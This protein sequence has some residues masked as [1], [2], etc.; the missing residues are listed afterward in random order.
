MMGDAIR[1]AV[2]DDE[3]FFQEQ[4]RK[5]LKKAACF[6]QQ[7]FQTEC[8][9]GAASLCRVLDTGQSFDVYFL[10]IDM[11]KMDGIALGKKIR[12]RTADP[13]IIFVSSK[14]GKVF[15]TFS[16]KPFQFIR[17]SSLERDF[18][19]VMEALIREM[20]QEKKSRDIV[21]ES[22]G[23]S[24]RFDVRKTVYIEADGKYLN[25]Y[26]KDH[27]F[28]VRYQISALEEQ[29]REYHF[30]RIH[31]SYLVNPR[32]IYLLEP[33]E[34][35]LEGGKH[36]PVSRHRYKEVQQEFLEYMHA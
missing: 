33:K 24:Y 8:F 7:D 14:E 4:L 9:S 22:G 5:R 35:V 3:V 36:L 20:W 13:Y 2:C 28:F 16:V 6:Y 29:L 18:E 34:A 19:S 30:L 25:V 32:Y 23:M 26:Q 31:K 27:S 11:P 17:K 15:E 10:D 12:E 21:L 1:I